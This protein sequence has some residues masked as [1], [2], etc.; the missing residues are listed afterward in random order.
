[1]LSRAR[2]GG[3]AWWPPR[4]PGNPWLLVGCSIYAATMIAVYAASTLSHLVEHTQRRRF[5]RSLDQAFIY[6]FIVGTY[7]PFSLV[8]LR[9]GRL[10]G[11]AGADVGDRGV[12]LFRQIVWEH[13]LDG[14]STWT[15]SP[16]RLAAGAGR[17]ARWSASFRPSDSGGSSSAASV[18]PSASSSSSSTTRP[19]FSRRLASV[20]RGR[21]R[22]ALLRHPRF[23]RPGRVR[24]IG[25]R[26]ATF[27]ERCANRRCV[28]T[29]SIAVGG[30]SCTA[31]SL[32]PR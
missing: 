32:T 6:T 29:R 18:T 2:R 13:R 26:A 23:R 31:A 24:M 1:M 5:F 4:G 16:A 7:T 28:G 9:S 3:A 15:L 30:S 10:V 12:G 11:A 20:R 8:Y 17:Q 27:G 22:L 25:E 19:L 21:N 14:P